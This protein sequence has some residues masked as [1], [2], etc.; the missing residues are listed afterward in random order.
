MNQRRKHKARK[1][2]EP[3]VA[4]IDFVIVFLVLL[5]PALGGSTAVWSQAIIALGAALVVIWDPP[6]TWPSKRLILIAGALV[7]MALACFLPSEWF[8]SQVW[9]AK[10]VVDRNFPLPSTLTPQPW[11][12]LQWTLL[13]VSGLV[14]TCYLT[15]RRWRTNRATL[16][17]TYGLGILVLAMLGTISHLTGERP[18]FWHAGGDTFGFFP[19]RNQTA[20]LLALG[21]IVLLGLAFH[22]HNRRRATSYAWGA[23]WIVVS[24]AVVLTCSR[25][26]FLLLLIGSLSWLLWVMVAARRMKK[27][28]VGLA[29]VLLGLSVFVLVG[30]ETWNRLERML[31][32]DL[33]QYL[34]FRVLVQKDALK[35]LGDASWHGIGLSN[36]D[37]V[38][39]HYR[40]ESFTK[41]RA[42]HPESDWLWAG[43][44]LGWGAPIL[45]LAG[46]AFWLTQH[47]P[48]H[49]QAEFHLRSALVVCVL[50]FLVHGLTDVSGHRMGTVWPVIFLFGLIRQREE[51]R[52]A[53]LGAPW[54]FR[55]LGVVLVVTAFWWLASAHEVRAWPTSA[56]VK[57]VREKVVRLLEDGYPDLLIEV[58]SEALRWA[59]LDD[60]LYYYRGLA[61][62]QTESGL[63]GAI[64]DFHRA[65]HLVPN[66]EEICFLQGV[67][68]LEREPSLAL[69][70]WNE[71]L[72][73]T[74]RLRRSMRPEGQNTRQ[75]A[76][77]RQILEL[78]RAYPEIIDELRPL[79]GDDRDLLLVF[80]ER[81]TPVEF[82]Q[83]LHWLL[84]EDPDLSTLTSP[85]REK[86]ISQWARSGEDELLEEKLRA[87]PE[88][89]VAGWRAY[90]QLRARQGML[91]E[92]CELAQEHAS[93]P[94]LPRLITDKPLKKL[95]RDFLLRTNDFAA[96]FALYQTQVG[97]GEID[98][99][100]MTLRKLTAQP[101]C[102]RYFSWLEAQLEMEQASW[103][104]AW[105]AWQRFLGR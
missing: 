67:A 93:P 68:W 30:G 43:I 34:D 44:E 72:K 57:Q 76:L 53:R 19:N 95:R 63:E 48:R 13:L 51:A 9:R 49:G 41:A 46:I 58:A 77:Y 86:F 105:Q 38:F 45:V 96:G 92:A 28:S 65:R 87:N 94:T 47:W 23:A 99:A 66:N 22:Y 61:R 36:F 35:L 102:P 97:R 3:N 100:L 7:L 12:S 83:E 59:P 18:S 17:T 74:R 40:A 50:A 25:G 56:R 101:E 88:W 21:G 81:A 103:D 33:P 15:A 24:T 32:A 20:N 37:P 55:G 8:G 4:P 10:L 31:Q 69:A 89:I 29:V 11:L 39:A 52:T 85:Q 75:M 16:L 79:A 1:I 42:I 84:L 27:S 91:Q 80:L 2:A 60:W 14:W 73:R 70:A 71:A 26:G 104:N 90:A 62:L 64:T 5:A 78:G 82:E 98:G 54:F 6:R